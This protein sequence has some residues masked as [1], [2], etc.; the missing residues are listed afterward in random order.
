MDGEWSGSQKLALLSV[1]LCP[2]I[3]NGFD[4]WCQMCYADKDI[5]LLLGHP[6]GSILWSTYYYSPGFLLSMKGKADEMADLL[7][8][9]LESATFEKVTLPLSEVSQ[10]P[11]TNSKFMPASFPTESH[12][13]A[14]RTFRRAINAS[15]S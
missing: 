4:K 9:T 2:D 10:H 6:G 5:L 15:A 3:L 8:Q 7:P 11:D 14:A 12:I 1:F 13:Y